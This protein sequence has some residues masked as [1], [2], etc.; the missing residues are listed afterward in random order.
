MKLSLANFEFLDLPNLVINI[1]EY[2]DETHKNC[3]VFK[4]YEA[5]CIQLVKTQWQNN[6]MDFDFVI[7]NIKQQKRKLSDFGKISNQDRAKF[8]RLIWKNRF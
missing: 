7:D 3:L 4:Q 2:N 8:Y 1:W 5:W 6:Y